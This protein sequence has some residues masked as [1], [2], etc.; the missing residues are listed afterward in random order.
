MRDALARITQG[1]TILFE[2]LFRAILANLD[3][4][5][6]RLVFSDALQRVGDPRGELIAIQCELA[7]LGACTRTS[8]WD[9][10]ADACVD[11]AALEDGR[12]ARLRRCEA[13]L[14]KAH[15]ESWEEG[16]AHVTPFRRFER[17]FVEHIDWRPIDRPNLVELN[18]N[19]NRLDEEAVAVL[20]AS[21]N[22][23]RCR[24]LVPRQR[25]TRPRTRP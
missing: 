8:W 24:V 19:N 13:E 21:P 7:R 11:A 15:G 22:L 4:D 3:D 1:Q 9:W 16:A 18:L 5:G 14:L 17:G 25:G 6:P 10:T 23:A 20:D 12:I 2:E